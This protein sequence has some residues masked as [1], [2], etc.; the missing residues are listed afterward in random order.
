M[1]VFKLLSFNSSVV[2]LDDSTLP[3]VSFANIFSHSVA[4]LLILL[5]LSFTEQKF[6]VVVF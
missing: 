1:I 6:L 3:D 4:C 2:F 5:T